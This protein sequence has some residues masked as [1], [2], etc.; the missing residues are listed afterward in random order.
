MAILLI[1]FLAPYDRD[2]RAEDD[3]RRRLRDSE[4]SLGEVQEREWNVREDMGLTLRLSVNLAMSKLHF[5][6]LIALE[7]SSHLEKC[8]A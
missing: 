8:G 5:R 3:Q 2:Y 4:R 7:V 1:V 6:F